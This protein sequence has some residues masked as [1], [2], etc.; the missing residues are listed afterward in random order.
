MFDL[1][2]LR[3]LLPSRCQLCGGASQRTLPLCS[4]CEIDLPWLNHCCTRCAIPL[5]PQVILPE[6]G[7]CGT[8]LH[9]PPPWRHCVAAFE[10]AAPINRLVSN[11]KHRGN[12]TNGRILAELLAERILDQAG[13]LYS[14]KLPDLLIPVPL[15]WRRQLMRGF[16]QSY[17]LTRLLSRQLGIPYSHR[18]CRKRHATKPQHNLPRAERA[19]NLRNAFD[20]RGTLNGL[21]VALVDDV[22]TT[23]ST[24]AALAAKLRKAGAEQVDVWCVARTRLK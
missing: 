6:S 21:T 2:T 12:L 10:Y 15:H 16:N 17:D 14:D 18:H 22:V 19:R 4:D 7:E 8:C 23:G 24:A 20:I 13:N 11:Y 9:R 5:A 1:N 3:A